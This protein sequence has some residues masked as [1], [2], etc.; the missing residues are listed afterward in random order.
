[1]QYAASLVDTDQHYQQDYCHFLHPEEGKRFLEKRMV[2]IY[3]TKWN[4]I[5]E[6]HNVNDLLFPQIILYVKRFIRSVN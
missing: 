5:T 2:F 3:W 1:M 4:Y 6:D